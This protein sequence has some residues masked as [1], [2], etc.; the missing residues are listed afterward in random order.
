MECPGTNENEEIVSLLLKAQ[1]LNLARMFYPALLSC[2][3]IG[4]CWGMIAR[5][6]YHLK[7]AILLTYFFPF[8][9]NLLQGI[10]W[11]INKW[12]ESII[13]IGADGSPLHGSLSCMLQDP[14]Y[15]P[16]N[17]QIQLK[18]YLSAEVSSCLKSPTWE[19]REALFLHF[20]TIVLLSGGI[21]ASVKCFL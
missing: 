11:G 6:C 14:N 17:I 18:G 20:I 1:L 12:S 4:A 21:W 9:E 16:V 2:K 10:P 19:K 5:Y 15:L 7:M 3:H 8:S 13:N